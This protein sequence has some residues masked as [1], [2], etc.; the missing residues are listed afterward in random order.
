[1][2]LL[3]A[4]MCLSLVVAASV[5]FPAIG[6]CQT[7]TR[8]LIKGG[9]Y[10]PIYGT[11]S[12]PV[13]VNSFYMDVFP[14]TNSQYQKFVSE[15]RKWRKS[16]IKSIFADG[17]YLSNWKNDTVFGPVL[18]PNSPVTNVSWFAAAEYCK[19]Q[20]KRLPT[21]DEWEYAAMSD[22]TL[23]DAR[24]LTTYNEY[25]LG[26]YEAPKTYTKTVGSTFKNYW[27]VYDLHGL[28]WEWTYDFNS[29]LISGESRKDSSNDRSLFCGSGSLGATDLM[30]YAAFMRYAFRGSIKA[31]YAVQ[32]LGFRCVSDLKIIP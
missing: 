5:M 1:M 29:V 15:N 23:P 3:K 14:V 11:D 12:T 17:N 21:V 10:A 9:S 13:K 19:C 8:V 26:W 31:N 6:N 7:Q 30:N 27:G 2:K 20:G 22:K 24:R 28:V 18:L 25:I 32:N 16:Q 4:L